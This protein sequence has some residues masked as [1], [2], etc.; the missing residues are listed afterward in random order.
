MQR[1]ACI[2]L[3]LLRAVC[4]IAEGTA[5]VIDDKDRDDDEAMSIDAEQTALRRAAN[6][7]REALRSTTSFSVMGGREGMA[8]SLGSVYCGSVLRFI[9]FTGT[10]GHNIVVPQTTNF[11]A[12]SNDG[13]KLFTTCTYERHR[14]FGTPAVRI[15]RVSDGALLREI[16]VMDATD[17]VP[18]PMVFGAPSYLCEAPDGFLYVADS[19]TRR[20]MVLTP[21]YS[22]HRSHALTDQTIAGMCVNDD[23]W[24]AIG[25]TARFINFLYIAQ[26]ASDA[27]QYRVLDSEEDSLSGY[28]LSFLPDQRH[29]AY[30]A[31]VP[32]LSRTCVVVRSIFTGKVMQHVDGGGSVNSRATLCVSPWGEFFVADD[33]NS[34]LRFSA[35]GASVCVVGKTTSSSFTALA[36]CRTTL[37]AMS[38]VKN[39]STR[40]S[41]YK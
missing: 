10:F 28:G 2:K 24:V 19:W 17:R 4:S 39:G 27:W 16:G 23:V 12:L 9:G 11:L 32:R 26:R 34:L 41:I 13:T 36:M 37:A 22:Y 33:M 40:V 5:D 21:E 6:V 30:V 29:V 1:N 25:T 8:R 18:R 15:F 38:T 3:A 20:V 14:Y 7:C 31:H 35:D